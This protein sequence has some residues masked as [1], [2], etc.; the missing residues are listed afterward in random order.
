MPTNDLNS[1]PVDREPSRKNDQKIII[2]MGVAG[3]GKTTVGKLLASLLSCDFF[4]A[5]DFH[6]PEN[7]WKMS[8]GIPLDDS[9]RLPWLQTLQKLLGEWSANGTNA[10]LACSA[11]K[12]S[13][14]DILREKSDL[15]RFV[16]LNGSFELIQRRLIKRQQEGT[17]WMPEC[18]L[19]S[20]FEALEPP[21]NA[22]WVDIDRKA[23]LIV[24][25]IISALG[26]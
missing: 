1:C 20:Q 16:Y 22:L 2:L 6:P 15:P 4:D 10:V 11:L 9:D 5:D 14:R 26:L 8:T 24:Q 21:E 17:S 19:K 23:E 13:Y 7:V 12:S 25:E 18:L 3:S